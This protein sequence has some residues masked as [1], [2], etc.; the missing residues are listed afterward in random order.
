MRWLLAI[1]LVS[2]AGL[3]SAGKPFRDLAATL[4][5]N[6]SSTATGGVE[7]E[8][9]DY[10]ERSYT[11][12]VLSQG[13]AG[14]AGAADYYVG[15][16][17]EGVAKSVLFALPSLTLGWYQWSK[18]GI[19]KLP[20]GLFR[21]TPCGKATQVLLFGALAVDAV[22]WVVDIVR[23]AMNKIPDIDGKTLR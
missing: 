19:C 14:Y 20:L 16:V 15:R 22:W 17:N 11:Y 23:Y 18:E 7:D 8:A 13:L 3:A 9:V 5:L 1:S 21:I 12:A 6:S 10:S 2:F 4:N